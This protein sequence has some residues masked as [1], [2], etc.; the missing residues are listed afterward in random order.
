MF[1]FED[2]DTL[3][4]QGN[5]TVDGQGYMWWVREFIGM[6]KNNRPK[7]FWI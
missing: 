6:N 3:T 4:V 1:F 2:V 5:G 7:L